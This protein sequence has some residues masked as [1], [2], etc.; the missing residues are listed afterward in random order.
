MASPFLKSKKCVLTLAYPLAN[1]NFPL[2]PTTAN[3][4]AF[5]SVTGFLEKTLKELPLNFPVVKPKSAY[6]TR[7]RFS[8]LLEDK[9]RPCAFPITLELSFGPSLR[10]SSMA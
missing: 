5:G 6:I 2:P 10:G 8:L 4:R 1:L 3:S 9:Y 7:V